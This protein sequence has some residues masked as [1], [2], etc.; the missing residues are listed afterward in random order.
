MAAVTQLLVCC[1]CYRCFQHGLNIR[2]TSFPAQEE[3]TTSDMRMNIEIVC[4]L[5]AYGYTRRRQMKRAYHLQ[6]QIEFNPHVNIS[7]HL[8]YL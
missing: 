2:Q 7:R 5:L 6:T 1:Q 3:H 8:H 4:Y